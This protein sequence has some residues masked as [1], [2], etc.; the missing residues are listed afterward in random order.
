[1]KKRKTGF[2]ILILAVAFAVGACSRSGSK[3]EVDFESVKIGDQEWMTKN[4]NVSTFRNGDPIPK[5]TTN[6]EWEDAG[7]DEQPAWCYYQNNPLNGKKYGR[8]YNWYAVNDP[9]GLAPEGWHVASDMEWYQLIEFLG[10][11]DVAGIK[12]KN[13]S[14]WNENGNG[15][16]ESGLS[17]LPGGAREYEGDFVDMG[18]YGYWWSSTDDRFNKNSATLYYLLYDQG[19]VGRNSYYKDEGYSVLCI[20][21]TIDTLAKRTDQNK[22][23]LNVAWELENGKLLQLQATQHTQPDFNYIIDLKFLS[24]QNWFITLQQIQDTFYGMNNSYIEDYTDIVN[25]GL[26]EISRQKLDTIASINES[27]ANLVSAIYSYFSNNNPDFAIEY[28]ISE[29]KSIYGL[30]VKELVDCNFDNDSDDYF[31][32]TSN[33]PENELLF[34]DTTNILNIRDFMNT[35]QKRLHDTFSKYYDEYVMDMLENNE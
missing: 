6:E 11:F 16:N 15:N 33:L 13:T 2:V 25:K 3:K 24:V 32:Y 12:M 14:G 30:K 9:R 21:T 7:L 1:M 8:L 31:Y 19:S 29:D 23:L 17:G 4:L 18:D 27:T 26:I 10:G 20:K 5:A 35:Y 22:H 34:Y 28:S